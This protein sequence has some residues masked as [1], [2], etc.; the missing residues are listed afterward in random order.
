MRLLRCVWKG[1]KKPAG[2]NCEADSTRRP[3]AIRACGGENGTTLELP[4]CPSDE[5]EAGDKDIARSNENS[6]S[7]DVVLIAPSALPQQSLVTGNIVDDEDN[8]VPFKGWERWRG[9]KLYN[10]DPEEMIDS[11]RRL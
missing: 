9:W 7:G 4:P 3:P 8:F 6:T 11:R 1:T 2:R 5:W 10:W